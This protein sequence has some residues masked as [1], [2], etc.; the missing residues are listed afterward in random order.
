MS[1]ITRTAAPWMAIPRVTPPPGA[2]RCRAEPEQ[3]DAL[4]AEHG[5]DLTASQGAAVVGVV[6]IASALAWLAG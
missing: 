2:V 6:L 3:A 1:N 4:W 5:W